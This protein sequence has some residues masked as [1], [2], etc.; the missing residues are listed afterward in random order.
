VLERLWRAVS[1]R[2]L[3]KPTLFAYWVL[4]EATP[5]CGQAAV[6]EPR[7]PLFREAGQLLAQALSVPAAQG[8]LLGVLFEAQWVAAV[9]YVLRLEQ[10]AADTQTQLLSL[11]FTSWWAGLGLEREVCL[12]GQATP[13]EQAVGEKLLKKGPLLDSF[14]KGDSI[15]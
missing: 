4:L 1:A 14:S 12:S 15:A 7:L 3:A 10:P 6:G 13:A 9:Q 5:G 8:E 2:A 11:A